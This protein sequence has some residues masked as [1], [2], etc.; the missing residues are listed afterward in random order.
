MSSLCMTHI[1]TK[2]E[3][4]SSG[5]FFACKHLNVILEIDMGI[6]DVYDEMNFEFSRTIYLM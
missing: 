4:I 2:Q 6:C 3:A 5:S 1:N